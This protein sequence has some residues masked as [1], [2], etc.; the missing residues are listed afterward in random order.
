[1]L[2]GI[3]DMYEEHWTFKVKKKSSYQKISVFLVGWG[4]ILF[5][6]KAVLQLTKNGLAKPGCLLLTGFIPCHFHQLESSCDVTKNWWFELIFSNQPCTSC[7]KAMNMCKMSS[8][9]TWN[10]C[11]KVLVVHWA[12][13][14]FRFKTEV[15]NIFFS[16]STLRLLSLFCSL[17]PGR[18]ELSA[19]RF[20]QLEFVSF[21]GN[22]ETIQK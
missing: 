21:R 3:V 16:G 5:A 15:W 2:P 12:N 6:P 17:P 20:Q 9:N 11:F 4:N 18:D 8:I 22:Q 14:A 10:V 7:M 1:M 19:G 13:W